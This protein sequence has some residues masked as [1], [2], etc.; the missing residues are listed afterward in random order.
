MSVVVNTV[1]VSLGSALPAGANVIG[2]VTQS[3]A[4]SVSISGTPT[5]TVGNA[6]IPVTDNGGS[7]TVDGTV[8]AT[9]SGTWNIGSITTL[10]SLAA[11][12]NAIGKLAANSGVNIGDVGV[13]SVV[14][15]TG[16]TNLGSARDSV[17]GATDTGVQI[18]AVRNDNAATSLVSAN[19]DY[20][21]ISVDSSGAVFIKSSH[22]PTPYVLLSAATTNATSISAS[23]NTVLLSYYIANLNGSAW[24]Y[25]KFYNKATAPTVG[26]D[27]PV[28]VLPI[29]PNGAANLSL[30][31][32]VNFTTGLAMALTSGIANS[33]TSAVALNEVV[34][35][36]AYAV[37]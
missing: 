19:G 14:P 10:P 31:D 12:T 18:L 28:M 3:G 11:G 1:K 16:A 25:V 2:A 15:G 30:N 4:W 23:A 37:Y 21:P 7:L 6:S 22:L 36:L 17:A 35:S 9:Q 33:D 29:P 34:V 24:K 13:T 5:V 32:G 20:S 27:V 26:T 8:A